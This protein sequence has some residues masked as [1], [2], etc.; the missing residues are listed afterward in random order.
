[1]IFVMI[2]SNVFLK[3]KKV[4]EKKLV[5]GFAISKNHS[6]RIYKK[7]KNHNTKLLFSLNM[8]KKQ[9]LTSVLV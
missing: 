6:S 8:S 3:K 4:F 5:R 2:T 9:V 7:V 1:M